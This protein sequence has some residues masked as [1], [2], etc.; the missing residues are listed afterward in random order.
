MLGAL[1]FKTNV[2]F[3]LTSNTSFKMIFVNIP[4]RFRLKNNISAIKNTPK[5]LNL[6]KNPNFFTFPFSIFLCL[7]IC[8]IY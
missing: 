8:V 3:T 1:V 2:K 4:K 6:A 7:I 5:T